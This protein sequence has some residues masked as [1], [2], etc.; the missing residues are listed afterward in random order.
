MQLLAI[1]K[2]D[3]ASLRKR[4]RLGCESARGHDKATNC[5]LGCHDAVELTDNVNPDLER[6]PLFALH[7]ELLT[8]S[9]QNK[10]NTSV[11]TLSACLGDAV[12]VQLEGL[13][14]KTFT[15]VRQLRS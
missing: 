3:V 4:H 13:A 15:G 9:A 8:G 12:A 7:Q 6:L 5:A 14:D 1:Q 2:F 11:C 10:V